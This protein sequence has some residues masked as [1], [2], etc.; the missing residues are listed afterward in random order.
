MTIRIHVAA[1][2]VIILPAVPACARAEN[3][4]SEGPS[5]VASEAPAS[6]SNPGP[7]VEPTPATSLATPDHECPNQAEAER[8]A[9]ERTEAVQGDVDG[10]GGPESVFVVADEQGSPGCIGFVV[11]DREGELRSAAVRYPDIDPSFGFPSLNSVASINDLAGE[12]IVINVTAGAST[13]FV[14]VYTFDGTGLHEV[15]YQDGSE[16]RSASVFGFGGSVGHVEAV[17]CL[18]DHRVVVSTATPRG[19]RYALV[20]RFLDPRGAIWVAAGTER[21]AGSLRQVTRKPEFSGSPF[22]NCT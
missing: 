3:T 5:P 4:E 22:L 17:D 12:E 2:L 14:S 15:S 11:V 16:D 7:T 9:G 20:R 18:S 1:A 19:R 10:D 8:S 21:S 6:M 13:Q